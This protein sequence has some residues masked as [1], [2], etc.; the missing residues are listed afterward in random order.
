MDVSGGLLVWDGRTWPITQS[1]L[2]LHLLYPDLYIVQALYY[3]IV[4]IL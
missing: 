4:C 3:S 1:V 2:A